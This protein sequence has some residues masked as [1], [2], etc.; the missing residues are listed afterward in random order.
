MGL[1]SFV[2]YFCLMAELTILEFSCFGKTGNFSWITLL[3]FAQAKNGQI[4]LWR[5]QI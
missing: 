5:V 3:A 4:F 2:E 1:S